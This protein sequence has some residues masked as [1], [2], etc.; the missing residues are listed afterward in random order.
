M[1][2]RAWKA[3]ELEQLGHHLVKEAER[4]REEEEKWPLY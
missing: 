1:P 2:D 4:I 3:E